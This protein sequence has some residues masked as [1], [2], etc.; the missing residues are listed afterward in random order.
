MSHSS[1]DVGIVGLKHGVKTLFPAIEDLPNINKIHFAGSQRSVG[2]YVD[3]EN[4]KSEVMSFSEMLLMPEIKVIFVASP[5][6]SHLGLVSQAL[7][8]GIPVYCE[9]PGGLNTSELERLFQKAHLNEVPLAIGYQYRHDPYIQFIK[10][11]L[12]NYGLN[13]VQEIHVKWQTSSALFASRQ[14]WKSN[15]EMGGDVSKDFLIH[16]IDYLD[17]FFPELFGKGGVET[18]R[19]INRTIE[20]DE[21]HLEV[22]INNLILDIRVTRSSPSRP[23]HEISIIGSNFNLLANRYFPFGINDCNLLVDD[24]KLFLEDLPEMGTEVQSIL[25][26][27]RYRQNLQIYATSVLVQEFLQSILDNNGVW[28]QN[29]DKTLRI[30]KVTDQFQLGRLSN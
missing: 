8:R 26:N 21:L 27:D 12:E 18:S 29:L 17:F 9:K 30:T 1:Y 11:R 24:E 2:K 22:E 4:G 6:S 15:K 16:V 5:P 7:E 13:Q 28:E 20:Y 25:S 23:E 10:K 3:I 14:I 19:F